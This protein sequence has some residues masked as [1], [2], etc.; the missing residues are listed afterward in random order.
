M[1][2]VLLTGAGGSA[3]ANFLDAV[4]LGDDRIETVGAD[5][6]GDR[7]HLSLA[8]HRVIVPPPHDKQYM[9]AIL[10]LTTEFGVDVIVPQPDQEVFALGQIRDALTA[11]MLLPDQPVLELAADKSALAERLKHRSVATPDNVVFKTRGDINDRT[12]ALLENHERVWVRARRGAGSRASLP[13]SSPDQATSWVA[14]W[15]YERNLDYSDFMASEFLPGREFAYQSLWQDGQLVVGQARERLEYLYGFLSPSGQ[16]SSATISRTV[17]EPS[18]DDLAQSAVLAID[19]RP[20]GVFCVDLKNA[21]DD[22]PRITE[23]NAGRFFTTSN[24]FAHAGLNMPRMLIS[25]AQGETLESLGSSPLEPDL[26]WVRMVDMGFK[27]VSGDDFGRWAG[28]ARPEPGPFSHPRA[29][30]A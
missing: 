4:R 17:A 9:T 13:V 16:S 19:E 6:S 23:I 2:T 11:N 1:L 29:I 26:Y 24:F 10:R 12:G 20:H 14:G 28:P 25:A 8:D 3:S 27:L 7:L 18:V 15:V 5:I 30:P 21:V 22:T